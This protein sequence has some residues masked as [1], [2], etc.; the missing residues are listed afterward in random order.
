MGTQ[1]RGG[2]RGLG[3]QPDVS[4]EA[5]QDE[6]GGRPTAQAVLAQVW[7]PYR[8]PEPRGPGSILS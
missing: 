6:A 1:P 4:T 8:E 3:N 5:S 7:Q 2:E